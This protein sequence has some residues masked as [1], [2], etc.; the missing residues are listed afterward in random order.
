MA[1]AEVPL[2][3][4]KI[5]ICTETGTK[6]PEGGSSK[7]GALLG[8]RT[9]MMSNSEGGSTLAFS[10][11]ALVSELKPCVWEEERVLR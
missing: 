3:V 5:H 9:G 6:T 7:G 11:Q 4:T 1:S 8:E 2:G 10:K